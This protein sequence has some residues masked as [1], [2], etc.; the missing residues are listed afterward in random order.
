M[1]YQVVQLRLAVPGRPDSVLAVD[2]V[3][4]ASVPGLAVGAT[5]RVRY[6]QRR[7]RDARLSQGTRA[8]RERNRYHFLIPVLGVGVLG[9]L[10]AWGWRVRR[11]KASPPAAHQEPRGRV[12]VSTGLVV[13]WALAGAGYGAAGS[14][15][16][17]P[18]RSAVRVI[19]TG[20]GVS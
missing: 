12:G 17:C 15:M 1:P 19:G 8:F 20:A 11:R 6:D 7:P 4:S 9:V 2:A 10:G 5:L 16:R 18:D 3:D 13:V 14:D